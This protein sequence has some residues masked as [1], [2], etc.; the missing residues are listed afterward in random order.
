MLLLACA[1][2]ELNSSSSKQASVLDHALFQPYDL[3][4]ASRAPLGL[5][6]ISIVLELSTLRQSRVPAL[7]H[8]RSE[9]VHQVSKDNAALCETIA[10]M[11]ALSAMLSNGAAHQASSKH[12]AIAAMNVLLPL[13]RRH[14]QTSIAFDGKRT[15]QETALPTQQP[16]RLASIAPLTDGEIAFDVLSDIHYGCTVNSC[17]INGDNR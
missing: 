15:A 3:K 13:A 2:T 7:V 11:I 8:F 4:L 9:E 6:S 10:A 16:E 5:C 12:R 17:A 14:T 1:A